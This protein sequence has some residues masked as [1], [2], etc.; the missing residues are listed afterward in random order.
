MATDPV[1]AGIKKA[2]IVGA[3][4]HFFLCMGPDCCTREEAEVVWEYVKRRVKETGLPVMR[5][6]AECFRICSGGPWIV[7]YP[8]GVWY[9]G[10][11]TERFERILQEHLI[12]GKPVE[13]WVA[14]QQMLGGCPGARDERDYRD[15]KPRSS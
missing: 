1:S 13:E 4:R 8:D 7:V 11:T 12:G 10:V 3:Q 5:T 6:K 14:V 15:E 2:G 9:G